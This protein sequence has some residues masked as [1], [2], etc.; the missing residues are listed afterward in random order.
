MKNL[1]I[2][3]NQIICKDHLV[4]Y[5][6]TV[7]PE[8]EKYFTAKALVVEYDRNV[9]DI[10]ESI[11]VIPFVSCLL[12]ASWILDCNLWV[13]EIDKTFYDSVPRI[14][15]AYREIY[16]HFTLKGRFVPAIL[17]RNELDLTKQSSSPS[18]R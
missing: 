4:N 2:I 18:W 11:L 7:S 15:E 9:E 17:T 12:S 1:D 16:D 5:H 3:L 14:R 13:R 8:L 6:F 10:P